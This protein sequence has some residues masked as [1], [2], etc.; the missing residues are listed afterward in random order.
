[1]SHPERAFFSG[2]CIGGPQDGKQVVNRE[3]A[4]R[5]PVLTDRPAFTSLDL[6]RGD[7]KPVGFRDVRYDFAMF[8]QQGFWLCPDDGVRTIADVINRLVDRYQQGRG[9]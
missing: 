5:V 9:T 2:L 4:Y 1:M 8:G 7:P 3:L 6:E